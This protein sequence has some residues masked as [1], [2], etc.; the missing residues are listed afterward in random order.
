M[1]ASMVL[2]IHTNMKGLFGPIQL[3][4]VKLE[5]L[6]TTPINST[7]LM[8]EKTKP[9]MVDKIKSHPKRSG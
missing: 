6:I 4:T 5:I 1:M 7:I 3:T 2:N 9:L 8:R